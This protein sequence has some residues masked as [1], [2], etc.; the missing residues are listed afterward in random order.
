LSV[1][2]TLNGEEVIAAPD[3]T[4]LDV[5]R[6]EGV[7]IPTLC[8]DPRLDPSGG[9]RMCL[10]QVE[11][12]RRL[13]PSCATAPSPA[14]V[15][16]T[17]TARVQRHR[18][19]LLALYLAD[20]PVDDAGLPTARAGESS[21]R[22]IARSEGVTASLDPLRRS[23]EGREDPNPYVDFDPDTCIG[24]ARCVR[25]CDEVVA[26]NAISMTHRGPQ[27][28]VSTPDRR[29]LLHTSCELCGGCIDTCPTGAMASK[30]HL[31]RPI[32]KRK[33]RTTCNFCGP[34][35]QIDLH[36]SHN[37]ITQ[38]TPPPVGETLNDGNL[39][40]KGRFAMEFV[41]HPD[42]LTEPMVRADDGRLRAAT[43]PE[44]LQRAAEGLRGVQA[45]HGTHSVG[46]ISS[47][48]C[49]GEENYLVQKLARAAFGTNNC[50]QCAAT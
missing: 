42:R 38:V 14:M 48:R 16:S 1:R 43:W 19:A 39:C 47:S 36:V 32:S 22:D 27:L 8:H 31:A 21:L 6:R 41:H 28:T 2:F 25:Y 12:A 37:R 45:R 17:D 9:C 7:H 10:V 34:G 5:A 4:I 3:E 29:G 40:V 24:C 35:C 46:F 11:G 13:Q 33:V 44:A 49:T 50:H 23:R 26:A 18:R 30:H 20:V 15:V